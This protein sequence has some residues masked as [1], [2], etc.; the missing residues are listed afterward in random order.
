MGGHDHV[1]PCVFHVLQNVQQLA[2]LLLDVDVTFAVAEALQPVHFCPLAQGLN[3]Q[4]FRPVCRINH[5]RLAGDISF[6]D[7][8]ALIQQHRPAGGPGQPPDVQPTGAALGVDKHRIGKLRCK[9]AFADALRS[10]HD[11]L[12]RRVNDAGCDFVSHIRM[13]PSSIFSAV[14]VLSPVHPRLLPVRPR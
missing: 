14:R 8:L 2:E 4:P 9:G 7:F 10:V 12:D 1:V 13:L 5:Q 3:A 6:A 11:H